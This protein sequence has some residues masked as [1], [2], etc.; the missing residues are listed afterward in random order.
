MLWELDDS[1]VKLMVMDR[2]ESA[3]SVVEMGRL[4]VDELLK[5][6]GQKKR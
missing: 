5:C 1:E 3:E 4:Y 6:L 2:T